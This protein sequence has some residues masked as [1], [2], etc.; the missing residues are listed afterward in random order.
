MVDII[1][2]SEEQHVYENPTGD[3]YI[4]SIHNDLYDTSNHH[5]LGDRGA[6]FDYEEPVPSL[7]QFGAAPEFMLSGQVVS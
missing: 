4:V 3:G 5:N 1:P 6:G 2:T 7:S